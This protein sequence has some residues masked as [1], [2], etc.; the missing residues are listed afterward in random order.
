MVAKI[1]EMMAT[2]LPV[3]ISV[4]N[5]KIVIEGKT[6][7]RKSVTDVDDAVHK[8]GQAARKLINAASSLHKGFFRNGSGWYTGKFVEVYGMSFDGRS[9]LV[10]NALYDSAE[11]NVVGYIR[12]KSDK[13]RSD[14]NMRTIGESF[15][16]LKDQNTKRAIRDF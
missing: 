13:E 12:L 4:N 7:K 9:K 8:S 1:G 15:Y 5:D 10:C 11:R 16:Y 3:N 14:S 6:Y 2:N